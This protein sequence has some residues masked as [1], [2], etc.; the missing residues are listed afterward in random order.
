MQVFRGMDGLADEVVAKNPPLAQWRNF[1]Y[2]ETLT[3]RIYGLVD[4]FKGQADPWRRHLS[5]A[6]VAHLSQHKLLPLMLQRAAA[7]PPGLAAIRMGCGLAGWRQ[8]GDWV[9][10][11]AADA[12]G[13]VHN[14]RARYLVA[15]DGASSSVRCERMYTIVVGISS[16]MLAAT[17]SMGPELHKRRDDMMWASAPH[18]VE[19]CTDVQSML[20]APAGSS[21]AFRWKV[22]PRCSTWSTFTSSAAIWRRC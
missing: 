15:A 21:W 7:T 8:E 4:H 20:V 14:V 9:A 18:G 13:G 16:I 22:T 10:L 5:P 3:G 11:R 2:C 12:G 1:V 17:C 19:D 6:P